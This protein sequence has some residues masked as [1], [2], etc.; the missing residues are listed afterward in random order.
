MN[1]RQYLPCGHGIVHHDGTQCVRCLQEG[2]IVSL[3]KFERS[4]PHVDWDEYHRACAESPV[5]EWE[6][7]LRRRPRGNPR[8]LSDRALT[9]NDL[10]LLAAWF[11]TTRQGS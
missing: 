9:G 8:G 2:K 6:L 3:D 5:P 10:N 11:W 7:C 1:T 4:T